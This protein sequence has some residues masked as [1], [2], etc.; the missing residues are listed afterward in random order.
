VP[1]MLKNV[2]TLAGTMPLESAAVKAVIKA[3]TARIE[4]R[5]R[6]LIRASGT[7]PLIRVM[8]ECEDEAMLL[9]V[10]DDI[11]GAVQAAV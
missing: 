10:V 1:Q 3:N 9:E 7:E 5:G 4:G 11:V 2:R 8:A 6:I